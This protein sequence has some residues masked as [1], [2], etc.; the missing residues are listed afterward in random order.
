M[1]AHIKEIFRAFLNNYF[2]FVKIS[3]TDVL[4]R[5]NKINKTTVIIKKKKKKGR[6]E[7]KG[8]LLKE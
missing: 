4:T 7:E 3:I 6:K 8:L 2:F 5:L 1:S